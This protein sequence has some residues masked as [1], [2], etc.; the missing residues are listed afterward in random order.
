MDKVYKILVIN[1]GSTST[2]VAYFENEAKVNEREL[3]H[4]SEELKKYAKP[5]D[6]LGMRSAAVLE[7]LSDLGMGVEDLDLIAS[8]GSLG[9]LGLK[10]G[11][12]AVDEPLLKAYRASD[13]THPAIL[14]AVIANELVKANP[15]IRAYIY[16]AAGINEGGPMAAVTGLPEIED[17]NGG[18]TLNQHAVGRM[19]AERFGLKY[20][21]ANLIVLHMGGG[22]SCG[23]HRGGRIVNLSKNT[24]TSIRCGNV[25]SIPL[26]KL[27]YSGK[28]TYEYL[29]KLMSSGS[30]L[31]GYLGTGDLREVDRRI[32]AGDEKAAFYL[33]AMAG[34][35]AKEIGAQA[36]VLDGRVDAI[37]L[38][39]GM[40][41]CKRLTD[42][43]AAKVRFIAPVI[44]VPG[45]F[46]MEA[47]ALGILRV[48]RGEEGVNAFPIS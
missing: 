3:D 37:A 6:Q 39:A 27:C 40:A 25:P 13:G 20:E 26:A 43:I 10:A 32:D 23:A 22:T 4:D 24:F 35:M 47:L 12:Y 41:R 5:L 2:K 42:M 7:Y 29:R 36:T 34:Q 17:D 46:E 45:A 19:V 31:L 1:P 18:H 44:V 9:Q 38:T 30:G 8:R 48:A 11:A 33:E 21:E 15:K 28:Y 16:D 14:G